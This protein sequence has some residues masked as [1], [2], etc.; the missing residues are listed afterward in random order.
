MKF[1]LSKGLLMKKEKEAEEE[2]Q[3]EGGGRARGDT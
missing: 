3:K 2:T 1:T